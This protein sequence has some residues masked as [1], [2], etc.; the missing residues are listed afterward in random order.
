MN[1]FTNS[2]DKHDFFRTALIDSIEENDDI[3]IATAFFN[4]TEVINKAVEKNCN[5]KLIVRLSLATSIER[6]KEVYNKKNVYIR[7]FTSETFHPK[8]YIFGN[9]KAFIGSSNLTISGISRNQEINIAIESDNPNFDDLK[10]CFYDYWEESE[11]LNDNIIEKYS[12]I[13]EEYYDIDNKLKEFNQV[14]KEKIGDFKFDNIKTV[15]NTKRNKKLSYI[16]D[17]KRKYQI[18]LDC[19]KKLTG[20]YKSSLEKLNM[21]RKYKDIPLKIET[22][23]FLNWI[24]ENKIK[25]VESYDKINDDK[26]KSKLEFFI[27]EYYYNYDIKD[28]Y[29][30]NYKKCRN[31]LKEDYI[32]TVSYDE[33]YDALLF[34]NAFRGRRRYFANN[35]M[36]EEF[37]NSNN[38]LENIK[39][40]IHYLL[41]DNEAYEI[42]MANCIYDKD[43]KLNYFG[44]SCIKE[45]YGVMSDDK[46]IALCNNRVFE[47]M[48]YLGFGNLK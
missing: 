9:S 22:D 14:L 2:N 28:T 11:V 37:F 46:N 38:N 44:E 41:Y 32:D 21:D 34:I 25:K 5:I 35:S 45:L 13:E 48:K 33:L 47:A 23:Q 19:Y 42:K 17:F 15:T 10:I 36:K 6:L 12:K 29:I 7:F 31:T 26:I 30:D 20:I 39:K 3:L 4:D 27:K 18:F 43:L 40:T 24:K 16:S 8:L 1:L